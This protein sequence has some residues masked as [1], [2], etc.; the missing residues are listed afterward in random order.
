MATSNA[1]L[2]FEKIG[3]YIEDAIVAKDE[4]LYSHTTTDANG[5]VIPDPLVS[6]K[7]IFKVFLNSGDYLNY[8]Q[9]EYLSDESNS[10][11][12]ALTPNPLASSDASSTSSQVNQEVLVN[13]INDGGIQDSTIPINTYLQMVHIVFFTKEE[14]RN[15]M[16]VLFFSLALDMKAKLDTINGTAVQLTTDEQPT[17]ND[18]QTLGIDCFDGY[19]DLSV[20]VYAGA[21]LS[22]SY[23]LQLDGVSIPFSSIDIGRGYETTPDLQKRSEILSFQ[24]TSSASISVKAL[25]TSNTE[26]DKL[27]QDT[28]NNSNFNTMYNVSLY[29]S[30]SAS[31]LFGKNMYLSK[32]AFHW[33]YGSIVSW[34][35]EFVPAISV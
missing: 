4:A 27:L 7:H 16:S 34:E 22:N 23:D 2:S 18:R 31:S 3:K 20:I 28:L 19:L 15:D 33:A 5:V 8:K 35:A 12:S 1:T 25:Y 24:N 14:F 9:N 30:G 29:A 21:K 11:Y 17:L 6:Q 13:I 32:V 26:V 10:V